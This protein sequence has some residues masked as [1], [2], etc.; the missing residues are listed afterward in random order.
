M[1]PRA[2]LNF[3]IVLQIYSIIWH[4]TDFCNRFELIIMQYTF[5]ERLRDRRGGLKGD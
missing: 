4:N 5:F 1:R 3:G 2:A